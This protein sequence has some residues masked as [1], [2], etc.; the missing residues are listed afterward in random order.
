M[1]MMWF[2]LMPYPDFPEDFNKRN[3]SV[4]VDIDPKLF[5]RQVMADT[6]NTYIDQLVYAED[7]TTTV[8]G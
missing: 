4:W 7:C 5:D 1:K 8:T 2:H 3:R 6:Y